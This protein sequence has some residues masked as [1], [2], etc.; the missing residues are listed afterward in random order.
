MKS[1]EIFRELFDRISP[2]EL[3]SELGLS[4][5]MIYKWAEPAGDVGSGTPNPLERIAALLK[6]TGDIRIAEWVCLRAGGFYIKSPDAPATEGARSVVSATNQIVQ[7][8]AEMLSSIATA[9]VDNA[10][11]A[12]ETRD[13]RERWEHLK[14]VTEAFVWCCERGNFEEVRGGAP[15]KPK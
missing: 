5:S 7:D 9:A 15:S 13:I 14:S 3:A 6:V 11:T 1:H 10:I 12:K 2:K 4:V 8:F